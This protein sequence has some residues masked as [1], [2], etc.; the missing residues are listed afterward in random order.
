MDAGWG[1]G[2]VGSA[3]VASLNLVSD[4]MIGENRVWNFALI[5]SIFTTDEATRIEGIPLSS[6]EANRIKGLGFLVL[7]CWFLVLFERSFVFLWLL[8]LFPLLIL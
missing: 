7:F 5:N 1:I 8:D 2:S 3:R 4:L 6:Y